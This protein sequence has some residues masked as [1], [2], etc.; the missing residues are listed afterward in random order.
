M[1]FLKILLT[2]LPSVVSEFQDYISGHQF[3]ASPEHPFK[4]SG[5]NNTF[6]L[7]PLL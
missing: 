2:F 1:E 3:N 4:T 6:L 7:C 5:S